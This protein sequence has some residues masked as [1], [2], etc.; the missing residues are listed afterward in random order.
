MHRW[1]S[2]LKG[3]YTSEDLRKIGY[4]S[5]GEDVMVSEQAIIRYPEETTIGSHVAIDPF[6]F[7][8]VK[9]DIGSYVHIST[10][11]KV[12]GNKESY[13]KMNDYTGLSA[14]VT[15]ICSSEDYKG[16]LTNPM[17]P[18]KYRKIERGSVILEKYSVIGA[19][20]TIM[21]NVTI[22]EGTA[23]GAKTLITK[24][25]DPWGI[26]IGIPARRIGERRRDLIDEAVKEI[27]GK[28]GI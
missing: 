4:K 22:G 7:I 18:M 6:V 24:N 13:M 28:A 15:V 1:W 12:T 2:N 21:P 3:W 5:V 9:M 23:I 14:G 25:L 26:Y 17:I 11:C 19:D 16:P 27:G 8:S 20:S 10:H